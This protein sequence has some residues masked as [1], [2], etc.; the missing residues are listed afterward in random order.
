MMDECINDTYE[1]P[2]ARMALG[3]GTIRPMEF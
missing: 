2:N 3:I 1:I